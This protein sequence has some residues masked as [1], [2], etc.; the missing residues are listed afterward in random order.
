MKLVAATLIVLSAFFGTVARAPGEARKP[1]PPKVTYRT[2]K[3]R[4][5][6]LRAEVSD[7]IVNRLLCESAEPVSDI[8]VDFCPEILGPGEERGCKNEAGGELTI[9]VTVNWEGGSSGV[10]WI[11][12]NKEG[13]LDDA[14][15]LLM[16]NMPEKKCEGEGDDESQ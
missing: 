15:R 10:A 16:N 1:R 4:H 11:V 12:V 2:F 7:R 8:T 3:S 6:R 14:Y 9:S 5:K 13:S